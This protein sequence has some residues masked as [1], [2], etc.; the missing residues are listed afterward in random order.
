VVAK[1]RVPLWRALLQQG[2]AASER[3]ARALCLTGDVVVDGLRVDKAGALVDP[4]AAI[5]I[6]GRRPYASRGGEKLEFALQRFGVDPSGRVALDC[7]AS[8]GGFTDCLLHHGA[9]R[10]YAVDVG[11]GQ[12]LGRLRQDL[13]VVNLERTNLAAV[14][15]E[16]LDPLPSLVT[17]DLSYL[18]LAEAWRLIAAWAERNTDVISLVKPLFE[19]DDAEARR[20][21]RI[22]NGA[23]YTAVLTRLGECLAMLGWTACGVAASPLRGGHGTVE[24]LVHARVGPGPR[25]DDGQVAAAVAEVAADGNPGTTV[26][27]GCH[28]RLP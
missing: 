13:R 25:L 11:W 6:R 21:G 2:V 23:A 5:R 27:R 9:A 10:I 20:S 12:L 14:G 24:F 8:T 16:V 28:P 7:G 4:A 22:A 17:L 1:S 15:R 3:E 26:G 18:P 19:V